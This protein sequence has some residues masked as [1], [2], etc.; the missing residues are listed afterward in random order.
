MEL[1]DYVGRF[2]KFKCSD[3]T[4][5]VGKVYVTEEDDLTN[6]MLIAAILDDCWTAHIPFSNASIVEVIDI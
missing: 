5:G 6:T 2:V 3:G 1:Q 4:F